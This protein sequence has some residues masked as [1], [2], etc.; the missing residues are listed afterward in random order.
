VGGIK[1]QVAVEKVASFLGDWHNPHQLDLPALPAVRPL[2]KQERQLVNI[3]GKSQADL[4]LGYVGPERCSPDY[5]PAV[6][7]NSVLGQFGLYG[8]I[9]ESVRE[10][11]GLAY[12]AYSSM[13][14]GIGPG[15]WYAAAGVDPIHIEEVVDLILSE[16]QRFV[17]DPVTDQ[18]LEDSKAQFIGRLPLSMESNGGVAG[19]LLNLERFSLGL[20]HYLRYPDLIREVTPHKILD[21]ARH[22]LD[23][24][25]LAIVVAGSDLPETFT[26][27]GEIENM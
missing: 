27:E 23:P 2:L 10:Q 6:L 20:D 26:K 16:I 11:S 14:G 8:R 3:P 21:T 7:G 18:E 9:G 13:S 25:R 19:A 24:D 5:M 15:P 22:Y 17:N 4:I 1:P 12:Y